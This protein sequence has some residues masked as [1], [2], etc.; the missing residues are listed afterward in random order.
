MKP[1]RPRWQRQRG[2]ATIESVMALLLLCLIL[3]GLVQVAYLFVCRVI[4]HHTAFVTSRSYVVGFDTP[5]VNRAREVGSIPMAGQLMEPAALVGMTPA[6]QGAIEPALIAEFVQSPDYLMWYRHWGRID[7][8]QPVANPDMLVDIK[9]T[10]RDYPIEMPMAGA[11][12]SDSTVDFSA[13][14][15]LLNHAGFYLD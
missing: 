1:P 14:A 9:V 15:R 3:F 4:A 12:M 8:S 13:E 11:Y 10:V 2:Q 6:E 7:H 5:I